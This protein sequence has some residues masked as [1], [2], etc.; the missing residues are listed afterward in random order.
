[1]PCF[2]GYAP[3]EEPTIALSIIVEN[4]GAGGAVAAPIARQV[5]DYYLLGRSPDNEAGMAVTYLTEE[6]GHAHHNHP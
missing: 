1:M 5:M 6:N 2:I 3:A 4:G